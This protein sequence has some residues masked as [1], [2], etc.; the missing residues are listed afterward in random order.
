MSS[1][2][3]ETLKNS[4][5]N[6]YG[7]TGDVG[8]VVTGAWDRAFQKVILC[9]C[10]FSLSENNKM[11]V[12]V[13]Y[14]CC[15]W[16]GGDISQTHWTSTASV[17]PESC[18]VPG[19]TLLALGR[20]LFTD[21]ALDHQTLKFPI[22]NPI[23]QIRRRTT[24]LPYV[25]ERKTFVM[26]KRNCFRL[27]SLVELRLK[28]PSIRF[29]RPSSFLSSLPLLSFLRSVERPI[30]KDSANRRFPQLDRH[31]FRHL[32]VFVLLENC[33]SAS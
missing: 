33:A 15:G 2:I 18:C 26:I 21:S 24:R 9:H 31:R 16:V 6:Q 28:N 4:F 13:Q 19:S 29:K 14:E 10:F 23:Q 11:F 32:L 20:I 17:I 22:A 25:T 8:D 30:Q 12:I 7:S 1:E 3:L 5:E 27:I